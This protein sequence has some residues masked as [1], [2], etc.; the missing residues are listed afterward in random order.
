MAQLRVDSD[1]FWL[2]SKWNYYDANADGIFELVSGPTEDAKSI[3]FNYKLPKGAK[4][5]SVKVHSVW[6]YPLGGF[7]KKTVE[8]KSIDNDGFVDI[9]SGFDA[10]ATSK[11]RSNPTN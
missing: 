4:V 9:T 1:D 3:T 8:N 5:K 6:S 7:A 11:S 2:T 10:S